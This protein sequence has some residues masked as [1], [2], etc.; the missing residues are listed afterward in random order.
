MF[1]SSPAWHT[2]KDRLHYALNSLGSRTSSKELW[3]IAKWP[4]P[5][6]SRL[7]LT[8]TVAVAAPVLCVIARTSDW[9]LRQIYWMDEVQMN[10]LHEINLGLTMCCAGKRGC[11]E[12]TFLL[13]IRFRY[14]SVCIGDFRWSPTLS[15][16][17]FLTDRY[18]ISLSALVIPADKLLKMTRGCGGSHAWSG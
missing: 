2:V 14:F 9:K 5:A 15:N 7:T 12:N 13:P 3:R 8:S 6:G 18:L 16:I 1:S 17:R 11:P 4:C 10:E